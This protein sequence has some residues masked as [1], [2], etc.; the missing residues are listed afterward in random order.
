[1][2]RFRVLIAD[3][4]DAILETLGDLLRE[5]AILE[6][7]GLAKN[8]DEA[9]E[10]AKSLHPD[11]AL[12]DVRMPG[13]GGPRATREIRAASPGTRI[14]A[15]SAYRE[16]SL[17][18][19]MLEA[20]AVGY[21]VKGTPGRELLEKIV[22]C[23]EGQAVLSEEITADVIG[24]LV[25]QLRLNDREPGERRSAMARIRG[26]LAGE[27]MSMVFQPIVDLNE[28]TDAGVEALARFSGEPMRTPDLWFREA[29]SLG[30]GIELEMAAFH[31]AVDQMGTLPATGFLSVNLAPKALGSSMFLDCLADV[32][33]DRLVMELT[34]HAPIEDYEI[35][36]NALEGARD[37]GLRLAVDDAGAGFASLRHVI[38]LHPDFIKVDISITRGIDTDEV[39]RAVAS[40]VVSVARSL[41]AAVIAEGIETKAEYRTLRMLGV[42][43]GQGYYLARPMSPEALRVRADDLRPLTV[44]GVRD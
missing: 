14:M 39:R 17:I 31:L 35:L 16:R 29:E 44:S 12:I 11:V 38:R 42:G 37:Q 2:T 25:G 8:A 4:D 18:L 33:L 9:I 40:G 21:L 7:V 1:V 5:D 3:D 19:E 41:G 15:H 30:V 22:H 24:E 28:G 23:A 27:G 32:P 34:E 20:G 26:A 13:G 36:N 6:V 10:L 43:Y